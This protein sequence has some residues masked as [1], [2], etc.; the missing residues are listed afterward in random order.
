MLTNNIGERIL[1]LMEIVRKT[2]ETL[3][4]RHLLR[5]GVETT[6]FLAGMGAFAN[7][8][9]MLSAAEKRATREADAV[10]PGVPSI[11]AIET[12]PQLPPE[13][14]NQ[15]IRKEQLQDDLEEQYTTPE[16]D[17]FLFG[18]GTLAGPAAVSLLIEHTIAYSEPYMATTTTPLSPNPA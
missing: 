15:I 8:L 7:G 17:L 2:G 14:V 4:R 12:Q 1:F 9:R 6:V 18:G 10:Y 16:Q 13:I 5:L 11:E 3:S